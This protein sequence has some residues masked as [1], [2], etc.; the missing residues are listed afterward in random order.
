RS[1]RSWSLIRM[2]ERQYCRHLYRNAKLAQLGYPS[3]APSLHILTTNLTTGQLCSFDKDGVYF[4]SA[5]GLGYT[6]RREDQNQLPIG[7]AVAASSAFPVL[8][9]PVRLSKSD[10]GGVADFAH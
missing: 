6:K 10:F 8:F 3:G 4:F 2:L 9:S 7:R 5:Q 1:M